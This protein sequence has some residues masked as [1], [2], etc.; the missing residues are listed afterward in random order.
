MVNNPSGYS[1]FAREIKSEMSK[2]NWNE[3]MN[4]SHLYT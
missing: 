3:E 4:I 2:I 1:P